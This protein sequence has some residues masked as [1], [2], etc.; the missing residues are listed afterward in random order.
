MGE[1]KI[2]EKKNDRKTVTGVYKLVEDL[3]RNVGKLYDV[4]LQLAKVEGR[5]AG[6]EK[7]ALVLQGMLNL[8][9]AKIDEIQM[10][11]LTQFPVEEKRKVD[12]RE[13]VP[14]CRN[15]G[16]QIAW[17]KNYVKGSRN[18]PNNVD[19]TPHSCCKTCKQAIV[20]PMPYVVGNKPENQDG[21]PHRCT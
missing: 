12:F 14:T 9:S 20:W 15:C 11:P 5:I 21:T 17:P 13:K 19:G 18:P 10:Q 16:K 8:V 2:D 1:E 3:N 7:L 6:V 4:P